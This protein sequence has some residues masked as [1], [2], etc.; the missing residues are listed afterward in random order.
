[1]EV[2][3]NNVYQTAFNAAL[4]AAAEDFAIKLK[5]LVPAAAGADGTNKEKR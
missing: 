2:L 3:D 4:N 1:M 5:A